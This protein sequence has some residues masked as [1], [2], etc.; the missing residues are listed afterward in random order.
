MQPLPLPLPLVLR[1]SWPLERP[2]R[3]GPLLPRAVFLVDLVWAG[4]LLVAMVPV[5]LV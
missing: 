4:L 2:C 3:S 5:V 1:V